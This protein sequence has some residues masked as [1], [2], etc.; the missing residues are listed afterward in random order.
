M[1]IKAMDI[2]AMV[3]RMGI[4]IISSPVGNISSGHLTNSNINTRVAIRI[5]VDAGVVRGPRGTLALGVVHFSSIK[6]ARVVR[7]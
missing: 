3:L 5:R 7:L 4:H 2:R 6:V 1:D